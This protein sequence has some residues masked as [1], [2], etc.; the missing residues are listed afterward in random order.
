MS[1]ARIALI[2]RSS[3]SW[4]QDVFGLL[5]RTIDPL[6][7]RV[8]DAGEFC[9][10][11]SETDLETAFVYIP[12]L[13]DREGMLPD[14]CEAA[15]VLK[16]LA[17]FR[18]VKI[19]LLSSHL[20]YGTGPGRQSL[21]SEDYASVGFGWRRISSAWKSLEAVAEQ[22]LGSVVPLTVLRPV[23]VLPSPALASRRLQRKIGI[24]LPGHNT[25]M[26]LLSLKDLAEALRCAVERPE[27]GAFNVAPDGV[28]PHN[29]AR[30][31]GG[32]LG[33]PVPRTLQ[34]LVRSKEALDYLR[35]PATVCNRKIKDQLG[36]RPRHSS[37]SA[38]RE[39]RKRSPV[40]S[41]PEPSFD[42]FGMDRRWIESN[43]RTLFKLL[44]DF[45][46]R[47]ECRG[48]EHIPLSGPAVLSGT[49][50]GFMPWDAVMA[51]HLILKKTGRIPRFLTHPGLFKFPF[52]SDFIIRL[53]GVL[54]CQESAERILQNGELLGVYPEGVQG[55][56]TRYREAY[57]LRSFGRHDF[58]K[59]ALRHGLPIIPFVTVGS[60][61]IYP[62]FSQIKWR[63]WIRYSDWPCLPLS[64]FPFWPLPLPT[65]WHVRFLPPVHVARQYPPEAANNSSVVREISQ[66][67]QTQMQQA[68][69]DIVSRRPSWF[70]GSVFEN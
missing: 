6:Q 46:W 60:A 38:L 18:P 53:G 35:Y 55:A 30:R 29:A 9:L 61:E 63:R 39:Y 44:S 4:A 26:Q 36:F 41:G 45:Y 66:A 11:A 10:P 21:V 28:A 3:N 33:I 32:I 52:I 15:S 17:A 7:W 13:T 22:E 27:S 69:D 57:K 48:L 5:S 19:V 64:T 40:N 31:A 62:V 54:A 68:L 20:I 16:R 1:A 58:V 14:L 65:K 70:Y 59:F 50:R 47:I 25:T 67:V 49:H 43:S 8:I 12:S 51:V 42:L 23:T 34:R 56:F 2:A 37:L 24:T